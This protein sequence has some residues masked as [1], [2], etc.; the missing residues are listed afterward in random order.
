MTCDILSFKTT[1]LIS[2]LKRCYTRFTTRNS[3]LQ[4]FKR[5]CHVQRNLP[6]IPVMNKTH[7]IPTYHLILGIRTFVLSSNQYVAAQ[8]VQW[9]GYT[10]EDLGSN[11][12]SSKRSI[13]S[14]KYRDQLQHQ[15]S[16]SYKGTF[17]YITYPLHAH[18]MTHLFHLHWSNYIS[19]MKCSNN[20]PRYINF[21][22]LLLWTPSVGQIFTW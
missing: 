10:L 3:I 14:P 15:P 7:P 16:W 22:V 20:E 2:T 21:S 18:N 9:I 1:H 17:L 4:N 13:S 5:N 12:N 8:S 6:G 19:I 11:L